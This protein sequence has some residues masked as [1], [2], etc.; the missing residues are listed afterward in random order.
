MAD[1]IVNAFTVKSNNGLFPFL[2]T[3]VT[4]VNGNEM[5]QA[6]AL[7]DTGATGT[8]ISK[9]LAKKLK[10]VPTGFKNICTPSGKST[11]STF[12]VDIILPNSVCI[13]QVPV[14]ESEIGLQNLGALIGMD[15]I[16]LGDFSLSNVNGKTTFTFRTPS[17]V[18]QDFVQEINDKNQK[19]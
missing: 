8:C 4:L 19:S 18:E 2:R 7:W 6:T 5:T 10:L 9:E 13:R 3:N 12:L 17:V 16:T 15:I 1:I 14:C 11:V